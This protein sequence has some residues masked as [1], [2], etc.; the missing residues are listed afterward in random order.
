MFAGLGLRRS[1]A[2]YK[3]GLCSQDP[4]GR[5]RGARKSCSPRPGFSFPWANL[6]T[7]QPDLGLQC[8]PAQWGAAPA[9]PIR[10]CQ[11][12]QE[13]KPL[14]CAEPAERK[15]GA[16][17][18][19]PRRYAK[20]GLGLE[21]RGLLGGPSSPSPSPAWA[22]LEGNIQHPQQLRVAAQQPEATQS[23][24]RGF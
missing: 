1:W 6:T 11:L 12:S 23:K 14:A 5:A 9:L 15:G 18:W 21:A 4:D 10:P 13:A 2:L 17:L 22:G 24:A 3:G 16:W 7:W 19:I 8:P 20:A